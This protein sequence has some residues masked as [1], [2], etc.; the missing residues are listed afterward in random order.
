MPVTQPGYPLPVKIDPSG[1]LAFVGNTNAP[2]TGDT[3]ANNLAVYRIDPNSG[4]LTPAQSSP[5]TTGGLFPDVVEVAPTGRFVYVLNSNRVGG[6]DAP[7]V[8]SFATDVNAGTLTAVS[9]S[10]FGHFQQFAGFALAPTGTYGYLVVAA[11]PSPVQLLRLDGTTGAVTA[12]ASTPFAGNEVAVSRDGRFMYV[13]DGSALAGYSVD[14][15]NGTFASISGTPLNVTNSPTLHG[16]TVDPTGRFLYIT[17]AETIYAYAI[18]SSTGA[19]T[20]VPGSPFTVARSPDILLD[21]SLAIDPSGRFGYLPGAPNTT[22]TN[23]LYALSIDPVT[24]ALGNVPGSP[25]TTGA[26][27]REIAFR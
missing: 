22:P 14:S 10:P 17:A 25:F 5:F 3:Q 23:K 13:S 4:M 26:D 27:P 15:S 19:I 7:S 6:S 8:A 24:G 2:V 9:G 12:G 20:S 21:G 18:D 11:Q 16:M 1:A